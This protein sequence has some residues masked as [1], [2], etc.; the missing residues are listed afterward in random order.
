[1]K[2]LR[3]NQV[4]LISAWQRNEAVPAPILDSNNERWRMNEV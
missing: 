2:H 4:T 3:N 1:M